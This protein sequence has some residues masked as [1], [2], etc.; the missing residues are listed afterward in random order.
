MANNQID[1]NE[2]L[3][4]C[5]DRDVISFND[6]RDVI[7]FNKQKWSSISNLRSIV[8]EGVF[9]SGVQAIVQRIAQASD[10]KNTNLISTWFHNGQE[11]EILRA[12]SNGWQKGKIKV[13]VTLEFIPDEPEVEK[14]P[15]D[16]LRQDSTNL[17]RPNYHD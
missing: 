17:V 16:D 5:D 14:S 2:Y 12:G 11:C 10:F 3:S 7:S 1:T 8:Y 4:N 15:L 13:N 6:D 9:N